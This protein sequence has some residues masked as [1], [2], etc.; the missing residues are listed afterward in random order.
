MTTHPTIVSPGADDRQGNGRHRVSDLLLVL[1]VAAVVLGVV[2]VSQGVLPSQSALDRVPPRYAVSDLVERLVPAPDAHLGTP[3]SQAARVPATPAPPTASSG[4]TT[5]VAACPAR[6]DLDH[7]W[8]LVLAAMALH[9]R[10]TLH[11]TPHVVPPDTQ[12]TSA[13]ARALVRIKEAVP[14]GEATPPATPRPHGPGC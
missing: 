2:L 13:K 4:L 12:A 10:R 3:R 9:K 11:A 8:R 7:D 1:V 6:L 14:P 5:V